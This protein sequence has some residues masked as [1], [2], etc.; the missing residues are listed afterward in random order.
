MKK[1][2][3]PLIA[4]I[5][6]SATVKDTNTVLYSYEK[7]KIEYSKGH[8]MLS[9]KESDYIKGVG[10]RI[11]CFVTL[12]KKH[13]L[14]S[15]NLGGYKMAVRPYIEKYQ[16]ILKSKLDIIDYNPK[17]LRTETR[18]NKIYF[19]YNDHLITADIGRRTDDGRICVG[20]NNY[21]F[22]VKEKNILVVLYIN[23]QLKYHQ[24][25]MIS[26]DGDVTTRIDLL[27]KY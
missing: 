4:L 6:L 17:L 22:Q 18:N 9:F 3:Y 8:L 21:N 12:N 24:N 20:A 10:D 25:L 19:Y 1:I 13:Y 2:L 27:N 26:K 5:L 23:N 11:E 16:T 15:E 14:G 7:G